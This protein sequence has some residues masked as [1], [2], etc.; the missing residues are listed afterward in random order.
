MCPLFVVRFSFTHLDR[1]IQLQLQRL[2]RSRKFVDSS[3]EEGKFFIAK[4]T[5]KK[6]IRYYVGQVKKI[7]K[8]FIYFFFFLKKFGKNKYISGK[9]E[10]AAR[11][12]AFPIGLFQF[13]IN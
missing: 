9:T 10:R 12:F 11:Q 3:I 5:T 7:T 2:Q 8:N 4:Y 1:L 13:N 6:S